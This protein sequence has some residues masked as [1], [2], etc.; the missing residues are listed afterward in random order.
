[1]KLIITAPNGKM[2]RIITQA[3]AERTNIE[4]VGAVGPKGRPY[5]GKDVADVTQLSQP[6]GV[7]VTDSIA[8]VIGKA[9]AVIDFSTV[10]ESMEVLAACRQAGTALA[11]GTTGFSPEQRQQFRDAAQD[12]P[13]MLA[14]NTSRMVNVMYRL[15]EIAAKSLDGA[16][17]ELIEMHD[18]TKLDAPSGTAG[19][20]GRILA[21]ARGQDPES[22]AVYGRQGICPRE[23]GTIG[24]H[25]I[26]GGDLI[27]HHTV[28]FFGTGE[29]LEI[30]HHSD[31][32]RCFAEGA[33]DCAEFLSTK[34]NGWFTA[35]DAFA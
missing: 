24:Y 23:P 26:R 7:P 33:I 10:E 5:I 25:S 17:I 6:L 28:S 32:F 4:I 13:V 11:C 29:W 34:E 3:A 15:L 1:M 2:G 35:K 27:S 19:E 12:A 18:N 8:S 16:D 20:M 14:A 9:D 21:E 30:A 31:N 22:T